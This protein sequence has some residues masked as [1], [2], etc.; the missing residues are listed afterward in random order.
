MARTMETSE[1]E[2]LIHHKYF[3]LLKS[4]HQTFLEKY[5]GN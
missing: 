2:Q 3:P 5:N 4:L 1:L